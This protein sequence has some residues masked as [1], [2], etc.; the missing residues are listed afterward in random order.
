MW[1][2]VYDRMIYNHRPVYELENDIPMVNEKFSLREWLAIRICTST[3]YY[4]ICLLLEINFSS[5]IDCLKEM[6]WLTEKVCHQI[7]NV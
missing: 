2:V 6:D 1:T 5:G 7:K 3:I 4:Q